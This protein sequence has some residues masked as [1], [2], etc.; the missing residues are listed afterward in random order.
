M[1]HVDFYKVIKPNRKLKF[2]AASKTGTLCIVWV[3]TD[4]LR[5]TIGLVSAGIVS[6]F[7]WKC[8]LMRRRLCPS[9]DLSS[10]GSGAGW[11]A[12]ACLQNAHRHPVGSAQPQEVEHTH[13]QTLLSLPHTLHQQCLNQRC[14]FRE[15]FTL[16]KR[17]GTGDF[18]FLFL[19]EYWTDRPKN[20]QHPKVL[21]AAAVD[22]Y[23][24][25][26]Q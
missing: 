23:R 10:K 17:C 7:V 19:S 25:L 6:L 15:S 3:C 8:L 20:N 9:S 21:E 5:C 11:E 14:V 24:P 26:L 12:A 1:L 13:S 4:G 22:D 2:P 16:R 18:F